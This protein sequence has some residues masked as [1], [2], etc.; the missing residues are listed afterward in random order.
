MVHTGAG[1]YLDPDA[2]LENGQSYL[3]RTLGVITELIGETGLEKTKKTG[4][5]V[6]NTG[7]TL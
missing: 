4:E 6:G 1:G 5:G 7:S 2:Q 3:D